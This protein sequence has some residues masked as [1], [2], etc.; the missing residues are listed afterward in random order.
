MLR[1]IAAGVGQAQRDAAAREAQLLLRL[2][3]ALNLGAMRLLRWRWRWGAWG[4]FY[5]A[6]VL[7]RV[8]WRMWKREVGRRR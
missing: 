3:Q 1:R 5:A 4:L 8:A 7:R 2:A 6:E